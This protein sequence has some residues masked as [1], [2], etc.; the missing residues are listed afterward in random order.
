MRSL[1]AAL[2]ALAFTVAG[3][4]GLTV[5]DGVAVAAPQPTPVPSPAYPVRGEL[6][7]VSGR[8]T[9]HVARA[10]QLEARVGSAWTVLASTQTTKSGRYSFTTSSVSPVTSLRVVAPRARIGR[11][12][13]STL[14]SRTRAVRTLAVTPSVPMVGERFAVSDR[15]STKAMPVRPVALQRKVGGAWRTLVTGST[16]TSGAFTLDVASADVTMNLRVVA[17]RVRIGRKTYARIT[18][19][20]AKVVVV[21]QS[22][23]LIFPDSPVAGTPMTVAVRFTPARPGRIQT[24]E[25]LIDNQ[26]RVL[27]SGAADA[28]GTVSII[29]TPAEAGWHVY[30]GIAEPWQGAVSL[31]TPLVATNIGPAVVTPTTL[32]VTTGTQVGA[33][34][35]GGGPVTVPFTVTNLGEAPVALEGVVR[36]DLADPQGGSWSPPAGCSAGAYHA[37]GSL[38]GGTT[39][40]PGGSTDGV[41]TITMDDLPVNQ[42]ACKGVSVPLHIG[43]S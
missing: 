22:S 15:L 25:A 13:Y 3:V 34:Q 33:L 1:R 20:T 28:S 26:W 7:T 11:K 12:T 30:R 24:L 5:T 43:L 23:A 9:S 38:G 2:V 42:D 41:V 17:Q 31:T 8:L 27:G 40:S 4:A 14:V 37:I 39:L 36:V 29:A 21:E 19:P 35:P 18:T 10:V 16:D 6:F 32:S